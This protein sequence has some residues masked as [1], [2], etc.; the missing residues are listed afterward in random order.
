[1]TNFVPIKELKDAVIVFKKKG[2][3]IIKRLNIPWKVKMPEDSNLWGTPEVSYSDKEI[4]IDLSQIS[5]FK[6]TV[7]VK[8]DEGNVTQKTAFLLGYIESEEDDD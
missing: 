1:M 7:C 4:V 6:A 8:D 3:E 5:Y 2:N